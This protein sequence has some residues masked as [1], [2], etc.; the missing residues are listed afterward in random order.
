MGRINWKKELA[1]NPQRKSFLYVLLPILAVFIFGN[2][3]FPTPFAQKDSE[4]VWARSLTLEEVEE[5]TVILADGTELMVPLEE[6][7]SL[8]AL[9]NR[10]GGRKYSPND[11]PPRGEGIS[12]RVGE[13]THTLYNR[14]SKYLEIDGALFSAGSAFFSTWSETMRRYLPL[15]EHGE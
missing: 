7:P 15:T 10:S 8:V 6:Y 5:I 13:R 11:P 9:V 4:V 1:D 14:Q 12:V 2:F 3:V